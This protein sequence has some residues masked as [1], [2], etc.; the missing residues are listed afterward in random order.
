MVHLD[1][2]GVILGK[3]F[4][5]RAKAVLMPFADKLVILEGQKPCV[6]CTK[7]RRLGGKLQLVSAM[8]F[9]KAARRSDSQLYVATL[10]GE[11]T[12]EETGTLVPSE[13]ANVLEEYEDQMLEN[14]LKGL[15][16]RRIVDHCIKLK[17]GS[18]PVVKAPYQLS[19]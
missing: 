19:R 10:H 5:W 11:V 1:D 18:R 13:L 4:L 9:K 7:E 16:P 15:P 3:D 2:F 6:V 17:P 8:S 14:L 12:E